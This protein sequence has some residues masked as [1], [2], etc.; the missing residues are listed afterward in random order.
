M[1][2]TN[3]ECIVETTPTPRYVRVNTN[4]MSRTEAIEEFIREGWEVIDGD[5]KTYDEFLA[6]VASLSATQYLSDIH[7][8]NLFVF[9]W[10]SKQHWAR[11]A[12]VRE[13]KLILQD[14]VSGVFAS[15][16]LPTT[17]AHP[18]IF[19]TLSNHQA[20]C[21]SS[22]LLDPPRGSVVLDM[23]AAPGMKTCHL[24]SIMKNRGTI[25]A[26]EYNENRYHTLQDM[27]AATKSSIVK[28]LHSDAMKVGEC[29]AVRFSYDIYSPVLVTRDLINSQIPTH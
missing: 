13:S 4:L 5:F 11:H 15:I 21:L 3:D 20:S 12:L 8:Q 16:L 1:D 22:F 26:V 29:D 2:A 7:V 10:S 25:F 23:C 28:P 6:A 19:I 17:A 18:L 24:A 9:P 14:K 27:V